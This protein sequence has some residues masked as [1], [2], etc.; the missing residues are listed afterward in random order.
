MEWRGWHLSRVVL[1]CRGRGRGDWAAHYGA[2]GG[3]AGRRAERRDR[4]ARLHQMQ[5][6]S[7]H[8]GRVRLSCPDL[9]PPA[10]TRHVAAGCR[11][12]LSTDCGGRKSMTTLGGAATLLA[13]GESGCRALAPDARTERGRRARRLTVRREGHG[14]RDDGPEIPPGGP[15]RRARPEGATGRLDQRTRQ[16][17]TR[18]R[19][20]ARPTRSRRPRRRR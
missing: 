9:A 13:S 10:S 12:D 16:R 4:Q 14:A 17:V 2:T 20:T 19:P 1:A 7:P 11:Q 5:P 3:A 8:H 15:D 6:P 18:R